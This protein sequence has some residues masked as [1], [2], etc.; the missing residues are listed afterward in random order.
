VESSRD[1]GR[2]HAAC[3]RPYVERDVRSLRQVGDLMQLHA[4]VRL[5]AARS[6][7]LLDLSGIPRELGVAVNTVKSWLSVLEASW[8][9]FVV[10]PWL[11][12]VGKRLVRSPKVYFNDTGMLD[13]LLG[14]RDARESATGPWAGELFET[15]VFV[16]LHTTRVNRGDEPGIRFWRTSTGREV[17]FLVEDGARLVPIEV[18]APSTPDP[19]AAAGLHA[20][21]RDLGERL[22]PGY[23]FHAGDER[24]ALGDGVVA[25]PIRGP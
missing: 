17:D 3:Q 6:A 20:V 4:F 10:R 8:L 2:W 19:Q 21:R 9:V 13:H 24:R 23:L 15:A 7:A 25:L 16:E 18:K 11:A 1:A 12:S 14:V 5:L 22:A